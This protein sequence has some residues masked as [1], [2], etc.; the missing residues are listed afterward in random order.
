M[1]ETENGKHE[2]T[3]IL[4]VS[5]TGGVKILDGV[6]NGKKSGSTGKLTT[7][8]HHA[9]PTSAGMTP[10]N[11]WSRCFCSELM[12]AGGSALAVVDETPCSTHCIVATLH[13]ANVLKFAI[14]SV[15]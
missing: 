7:R 4:E 13:P 1:N 12:R 8:K 10:P 14:L 2:L 3:N 5:R 11:R 6:I 15:Y 9:L